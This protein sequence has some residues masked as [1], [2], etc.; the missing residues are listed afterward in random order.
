PS[1]LVETGFISNPTEEKLL[2]QRSHQ[3]K[4][5]RALTTAIVQ[6][7]ENNAPEGTLFA[8]R[9]KTIKH[10][11]QKGESLSVIANRYGTTVTAIRN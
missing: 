2:F 11:V 6:Y 9:S 10:K 7:F 8:N 4:L 3:D 1:V 5:A